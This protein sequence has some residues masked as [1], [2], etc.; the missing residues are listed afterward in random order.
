MTDAS[1]TT[2]PSNESSSLSTDILKKLRR[3]KQI[4]TPQQ[5]FSHALKAGDVAPDFILDDA[6]N[7]RISLYDQLKQGPVILSFIDG[8]WQTSPQ[9]KLEFYTG[10]LHQMK[11]TGF[12]LMAV[13]TDNKDHLKSINMPL[14]AAFSV[15]SD[16]DYNVARQY[17]L[18]E[19]SLCP[20]LKGLQDVPTLMPVPTTFL[21]RADGVIHKVYTNTEFRQHLDPSLT[22]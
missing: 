7:G 12:R 6:N 18:V 4:L 11:S 15:A 19:P 8:H 20:T 3:I 1:L 21:I 9:S 17:G 2:L 14:D 13:L 16:Y 10:F 22:T 5:P